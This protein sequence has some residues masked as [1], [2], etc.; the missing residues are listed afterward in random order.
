MN[1]LAAVSHLPP[2]GAPLAGTLR[3]FRPGLPPGGPG[4]SGGV[5]TGLTRVEGAEVVGGDEDGERGGDGW[6]QERSRRLSPGL[7]PVRSPG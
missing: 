6:I 4:D 2:S 5:E 3:H 1:E 7:D